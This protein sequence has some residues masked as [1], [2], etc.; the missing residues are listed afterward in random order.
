MFDYCNDLGTV[1]FFKNAV[2]KV[3]CAWHKEGVS[4]FSDAGEKLFL[5][6]LSICNLTKATGEDCML[7]SKVFEN[8]C[9]GL[10]DSVSSGEL[11]LAQCGPH[12]AGE[13]FDEALQCIKDHLECEGGIDAPLWFFLFIGFGIGLTL[14]VCCTL[15]R[16]LGQI[17]CSSKEAPLLEN[18]D[19]DKDTARRYG[20]IEM[21]Q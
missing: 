14:T 12:T 6:A 7:P 2:G 15:C 13:L 8:V 4:S 10:T 9:A 19:E 18:E 5:K 21:Q 16:I 1:G 17:D 20:A 11:L 3:F